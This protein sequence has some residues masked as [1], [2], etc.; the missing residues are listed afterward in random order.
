MSVI[1]L[2]SLLLMVAGFVGLLYLAWQ[3]RNAWFLVLAAPAPILIAWEYFDIRAEYLLLVVGLGIFM[4]FV[5]SWQI[6]RGRKS[7]ET[8]LLASE[9]KYRGIF[10]YAEVGLSQV[11]LSDFRMLDCNNRA[12]RVLG[13]KN[14]E[15]MKE[16]YDPDVHWLEPSVLNAIITRGKKEQHSIDQEVEIMRLDGSKCWLRM[17]VTFFPEED[18]LIA[19]SLDVTER[20]QVDEALRESEEK[21]RTIF[22]NAQV[23]LIRTRLSDGTAIDANG[24]MADLLGYDDPA[25]LIENF[26]AKEMYVDKDQMQ[27]VV[28]T[29]MKHGVLKDVEAEF[30]RKDRSILQA[31]FYAKFLREKGQIETV[32]LDIGEQKQIQ[33]KLISALDQAEQANR[34]KSDFLAN[35]SHELRTPLNAILGFSQMIR[36]RSLGD[37]AEERYR[38]YAG[39]IYHS[40]DHLLALIG[41]ILDLSKIEAGKARINETEFDIERV[42]N[43]SVLL[44][45]VRAEQAGLSLNVTLNTPPL[46]LLADERMVK[47]M[48]LNLLTNAVKFTSAGGQVEVAT[49]MLEDG[50]L[51][52]TVSDTGIGIASEDIPKT[53]SLFGQVGDVLTRV[54]EGTGLGLPLVASQAELHGGKL[55]IESEPNVGTQVTIWFP[56][57]RCKAEIPSE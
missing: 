14:S 48:L 54:E 25:D 56:A 17:A 28:Q 22:D 23:G 35:M 43:A 19:V 12:A 41:D 47:Q 34:S 52:I 55:E 44:M 15:D 57:H 51:A 32:V 45:Q 2:S 21:Y 8:S 50:R 36:D 31:R 30:Y 9:R 37:N 10:E 7:L 1:A 13:Y 40:G 11:R 18:Y 3:Y 6:V 46:T 20:R 16:N 42:I 5:V 26:N 38:E 24:R 27:R 49:Q 33:K 29:G 53:L 4:T 39:D